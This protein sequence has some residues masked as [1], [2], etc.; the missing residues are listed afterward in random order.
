MKNWSGNNYQVILIRVRKGLSEKMSEIEV[1]SALTSEMDAKTVLRLKLSTTVNRNSKQTD[2]SYIDCEQITC[3]DQVLRLVYG[4]RRISRPREIGDILT[5]ILKK[6]MISY[7]FVNR[8]SIY[9]PNTKVKTEIIIYKVKNYRISCQTQLLTKTICFLACAST[10][11]ERNAMSKQY[12]TDS[13]NSK[14]S[15]Q[16]EHIQQAIL[17]PKQYVIKYI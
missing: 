14:I 8:D 4:R 2:K 5:D 1:E 6:M 11:A 15:G 10:T 16:I 7:L 13:D 17:N 3:K 12:G 9:T